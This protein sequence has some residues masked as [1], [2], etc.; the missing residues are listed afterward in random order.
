MYVSLLSTPVSGYN[1]KQMAKRMVEPNSGC[2][3]K[4]HGDVADGYDTDDDKPLNELAPG[5]DPDDDIPLSELVPGYEPRDAYPRMLKQSK[6]GDVANGYDTDDDKP[7]NELVPGYDPDDDKPL[8]ELVPGYEPREA[9][10]RMLKQ[11]V[12]W[13]VRGI[14][15]RCARKIC[16]ACI[17]GTHQQEADDFDDNKPLSEWRLRGSD[18][19]PD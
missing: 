2:G 6:N 13:Q 18:L 19:I 12:S 7:L 11:Y 3:N 4:P 17:N 10:P 14:R 16:V 15:F 9:Y 1:L 5:Y 8:S